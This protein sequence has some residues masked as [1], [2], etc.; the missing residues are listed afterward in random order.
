MTFRPASRRRF[1]ASLPLWG[2]VSPALLKAAEGVPVEKEKFHLYLLIGQSNMAGRGVI[3]PEEQDKAPGRVLKFTKENAW[4]PAT[5]PLHFDK[6]AIAGVG[7][8]TSFGEAMAKAE[9][10]ATI[11]LV[12]CAFGGTPL[13]RWLPAGDLYQ[14]A[15]ARARAAAEKGTIKGIL[16]HQGENDASKQETAGSYLARLTE[17]I[18][19]WRKDLEAPGL[20]FVAGKLGDFLALTDK[21][22]QPNYWRE[23][24]AQLETL[25][26]KVPHTAVADSAG[27]KAK[28]DQVHFDTAALREFGRRYAAKMLAL[29]GTR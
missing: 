20:P 9:P 3:A 7:L 22:G 25:P 27:L 28:S 29:Q 14:G 26:D 11:G 18:A 24:N 17:A 16:W 12:P 1:L 10:G 19:G 8:G 23:I 2:L 15:L 5:D 6:P 13:E 21:E 4:A